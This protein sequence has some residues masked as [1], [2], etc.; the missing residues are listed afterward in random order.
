[1][2]LSRRQKP[3][4]LRCPFTSAADSASPVYT[5]RSCESPAGVE[6]AAGE[7]PRPLVTGPWSRVRAAAAA[8]RTTPAFLRGPPRASSFLALS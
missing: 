6:P 1:M 8:R 7:G 5:H 4:M 2:G 3:L